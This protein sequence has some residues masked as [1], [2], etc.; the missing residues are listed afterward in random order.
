MITKKCDT[1][2]NEIKMDMIIREVYYSCWT[3]LRDKMYTSP[4]MMIPSNF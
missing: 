3:N 4:P 2:K 1:N